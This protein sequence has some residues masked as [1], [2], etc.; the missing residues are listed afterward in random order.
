MI[1]VWYRGALVLFRLLHVIEWFLSIG[2]FAF[3]VREKGWLLDVSLERIEGSH[4]YPNLL[5]SLSR[6]QRWLLIKIVIFET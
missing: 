4:L 5:S 6:Q 2:Q 3:C 1:I